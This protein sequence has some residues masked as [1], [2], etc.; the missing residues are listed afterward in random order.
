MPRLDDLNAHPAAQPAA[1]SLGRR[2]FLALA[3][4]AAATSLPAAAHAH[5]A[6]NGLS[7]GYLGDLGDLGDLGLLGEAQAAP[8]LRSA[9]GLVAGDTDFLRRGVRLSVLGLGGQRSAH[10]QGV[11]LLAHTAVPGLA[12]PVD[13]VHW[14]MRV[15]PVECAACDSEQV[16][17]LGA[18]GALRLSLEVRHT[19]QSEKRVLPVSLTSGWRPGVAKLQAGTYLLAFDF[20]QA[21]PNWSNQA[22]QQTA[23]PDAA[24]VE[25]AASDFTYLIVKVDHAS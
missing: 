12:Q 21:A 5:T 16:L 7:V 24:A 18:D 1:A 4:G 2:D 23:D 8:R 11:T 6:P 25:L 3:A 13:V 17:A 19:T 15:S 22:V 20:A 10:L 14:G 9:Q